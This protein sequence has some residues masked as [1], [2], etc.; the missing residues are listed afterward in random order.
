MK[1]ALCFFKA[2]TVPEYKLYISNIIFM[3]I[4]EFPFLM[5][6]ESVKPA[7][8]SLD[9]SRAVFVSIPTNK[10]INPCESRM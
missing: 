4:A 1:D 3:Q 2:K 6:Y 9:I 7:D 8:A 10:A 5:D